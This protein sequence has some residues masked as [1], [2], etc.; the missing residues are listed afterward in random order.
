MSSDEEEPVRIG[1]TMG[2]QEA[3]DSDV[4]DDSSST[5]DG[6]GDDLILDPDGDEVGEMHDEDFEGDV[7]LKV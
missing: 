7:F 6:L 3:V 1:N 4:S 5:D 2:D